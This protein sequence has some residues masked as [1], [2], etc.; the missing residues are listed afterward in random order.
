V[1]AA[2]PEARFPRGLLRPELYIG[3]I[4]SVSATAV[5]FSIKTAGTPSGSHFL[6]GRYGKGEVGEFVLIEGQISLLLGRIVEIHL[7][8]AD[9]PALDA[10]Q[11]AK[12]I[13]RAMGTIHGNHPVARIRCNGFSSSVAWSR[14]LSSTW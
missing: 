2:E 11:P 14:V 4:A 12:Q 3:Q 1:N 6:G 9:R 13:A 8:E 7:P 10:N 5:Q